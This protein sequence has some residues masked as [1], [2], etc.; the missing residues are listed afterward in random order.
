MKKAGKIALVIFIIIFVG[1]IAVGS[2]ILYSYNNVNYQIDDTTITFDIS[3][4]IFDGYI[5]F[6]K[7]ETPAS[8][9]NGGLY[10]IKNLNIS[11]EVFG[12]NFTTSTLNGALLSKGE[13]IV[14]NI[15][16]KVNWSG[17]IFT[18][19][20]Y[21]IPLLAIY[22]GDLM[23][24]IDVSFQIDFVLFKLPI[25]VQVIQIVNWDAPFSL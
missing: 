23:I 15:D 24:Y 11:I 3:F 8:I 10:D 6:I 12:V 19:I 9:Q 7:T 17:S 13:N 5:G 1:V 4:D 16:S 22:D 2:T 14:G 25:N 18:N 21:N 20:T